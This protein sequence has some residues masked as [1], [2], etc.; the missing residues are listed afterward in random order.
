M[1]FY[2]AGWLICFCL[3]YRLIWLASSSQPSSSCLVK[4]TSKTASTAQLVDTS[5][6]EPSLASYEFFFSALVFMGRTCFAVPEGLVPLTH[7]P[8]CSGSHMLVKESLYG[9]AEATLS[10]LCGTSLFNFELQ[11][12]HLR[13]YVGH[14]HLILNCIENTFVFM[15]DTL[16]LILECARIFIM[17]VSKSISM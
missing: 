5:R 2:W 11:R 9:S 15:R 3:V 6:V 10:Y 13:I 17:R 16:Y 14:P 1:Y 4:L 12:K 8:R 7:G